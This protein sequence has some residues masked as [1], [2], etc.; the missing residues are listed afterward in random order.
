MNYN[1]SRLYPLPVFLPMSTPFPIPLSHSYLYI[2]FCDLLC[3]I[4][5]IGLIMNFELSPDPV[6]PPEDTQQ[7]ILTPHSDGH[8]AANGLWWKANAPGTVAYSILLVDS[9]S[10]WLSISGNRSCRELNIAVFRR[11]HLTAFSTISWNVPFM[12]D[13]KGQYALFGMEHPTLISLRTLKSSNSAHIT[14]Y[15]KDRL[16]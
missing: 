16:L 8:A 4:K 9:A 14:I 5:V 7:K 3:L 2:L 1:Y 12:G 15:C 13:W 10:L 6:G 11:W